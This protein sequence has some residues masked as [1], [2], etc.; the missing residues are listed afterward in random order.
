[1]FNNKIKIMP[2][3]S[4]HEIQ[5]V[6]NLMQRVW[7]L[8][9]REV[10]STYEMKAISKFGVLIGAY[11]ENLLVG[12][13]YAF[14]MGN[15]RHYSHMM[16]ID[17]K[18]QGQNVGLQLKLY[19]RELALKQGIKVIEWTVDPLLPNKNY[20]NFGKLGA[21][22]NTYYENYYGNPDTTFSIYAGLETDRFL[23]E[24]HLNHQ[25]VVQKLNKEPK[26]ELTENTFFNKYPLLN[27]NIDEFLSQNKVNI[28]N[29]DFSKI[30]KSSIW[31]IQVPA[32]FQKLK[33]ENIDIAKKWRIYFRKISLELF[34]RGYYA[35]DYAVFNFRKQDQT[36]YYIFMQKNLL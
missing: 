11:Y 2:I 31:S 23:A 13:I 7:G 17:E 5:E 35:C 30:S 14:P 20:L 1:M 26:Q 34:T 3:D 33:R 4:M 21:F 28:S 25:R 22:C 16:G 10:V 12:F 29:I 9:D 27:E 19:H 15:E 18:F 36:N 24:W 8:S 32:N 6:A